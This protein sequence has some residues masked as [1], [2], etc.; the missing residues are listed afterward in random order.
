MNNTNKEEPLAMSL[1]GT[2][3]LIARVVWLWWT[4]W[5]RARVDLVNA[6]T[7]CPLPNITKDSARSVYGEMRSTVRGSRDKLRE[8]LLL[9][10]YFGAD[11]VFPEGED[12]GGSRVKPIAMLANKV[13]GDVTGCGS[14]VVVLETEQQ[15]D[16]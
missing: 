3:I 15:G 14:L 5:R 6:R 13:E 9:A 4:L 7:G 12:S 2:V 10:D 1:E 16:K 8:L 11:I